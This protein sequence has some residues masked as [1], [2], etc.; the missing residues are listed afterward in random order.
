MS[1][2]GAKQHDRVSVISGS[3]IHHRRRCGSAICV[4][5]CCFRILLDADFRFH[6]LFLSDPKY[7]QRLL[8]CYDA[9]V[10]LFYKGGADLNASK[11][12]A[13][14]GT[15]SNTEY[16]KLFTEKLVKELSAIQVMVVSG[17]AFG[18]DAIAH[19]A[20]L[21]NKLNTLGVVGHGLDQIY[22][23]EHNNLAKEIVKEGG[24]I[25]TEFRKGTKPDKHNFPGRNRI[26]AGI[27]DATIV[28]ES[29]IKGGSL[30]TAEL[31]N[32]YNRDVFAVPG[33]T[34]DNKSAGCNHLIKTNKAVLLT[35]AKD[36]IELMGWEQNPKPSRKIQRQLFIQ[37]SKEEK[38]ILDIL[39][40]KEM[41][42]IDE[43]N[44]RTG[45]SS[46]TVAAA[47]LN[48]ELQNVIQS[49]PGKIYKLIN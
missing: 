33:K 21:K 31:A 36:L 13:I 26:V 16:G 28:V 11:I 24:G 1:T 40:E 7:P 30:I 15:R 25:L 9:P 46:S 44:Q 41:A 37:F 32:G 12:L 39:N 5:H 2:G 42:H 6:P 22:P 8:N 14:V 34:T 4:S 29:G 27:S 35:E 17:L 48:L 47:I 45:L 3:R 18:I 43:L 19:K 20:A 10:L 38:S 23:P 49:L